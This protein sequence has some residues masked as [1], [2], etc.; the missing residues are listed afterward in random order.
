MRTAS[1]ARRNLTGICAKRLELNRFS[2]TIDR[3]VAFVMS[4]RDRMAAIRV[5]QPAEAPGFLEGS[6]RAM[7]STTLTASDR[8]SDRLVFSPC[9]D[10][11]ALRGIKRIMDVVGSALLLLV[12]SPFL[13]VIAIL[14]KLSS[15]GPVFYRWYVAGEGGH[16]FMS[17]KFRSMYANADQIKAQ[18]AHLN[19]M[20][21]PAFKITGD[22]RITPLGR[23]IRRYSLDELPQL[24]SVLKGDMALVGPRPPLVNEYELFTPYQK[25]KMSV[26]PGL[27][28]LWQVNGRNR[29]NDYDDWVRLDLEYIRTWSIWLD[30]RILLKTI[31]EVLRGSGK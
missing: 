23:W 18:L 30:I 24:Y 25:Q 28:C 20:R 9:W 4:V 31:R 2:A 3:I 11:P 1:V 13:V 26:R 27:T 5:R 22:P 17:Y 7:N 6:V 16:P 8:Q 12:L 29:I 19:E 21:G 15:D 10:S 14:V